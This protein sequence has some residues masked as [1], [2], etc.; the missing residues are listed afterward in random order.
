MTDVDGNDYVDLCCAFGS[1]MSGH[2]HPILQA[3]IKNQLKDGTLFSAPH[4][5]YA[6]VSELL[7]QRFPFDKVRFTNS[8]TESTHDALRVARAFTGREKVV[9][10][11]GGYHGHNELMVSC[12]PPLDKAGD[13]RAPNPILASGGIPQSVLHDTLV[14]PFNDLEALDRILTQHKGEVAAFILEPAPQN[15][16]IVVPDEGYIR[17]VR[18]ITKKHGVL[19]ICDEVKTGITSHWGGA[20]TYFGIQPDLICLAKSIGGGVPVGVF[21]GRAEIMEVLS[22]GKALHLGT[23]NGNSLVLAATRAVLRDIVTPEAFAE[24]KS[25]NERMVNEIQKL[26]NAYKIPAH[27]VQ[28]GAKGCVTFSTH[29]VRNYRDYK[30]TD[31]D[32]ALYHWLFMAN[33]GIFLPPGLDD[34][35]TMS[36]QH[37]E[38]DLDRHVFLFEQFCSAL[39]G[40]HLNSYTP[41]LNSKL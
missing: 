21:G 13:P 14:V 5:L 33:R 8:G 12:K 19:M 39:T 38:A 25:R 9:K 27:T 3:A 15:M 40:K 23:Y 20:S 7:I 17:G 34:Q 24:A 4:D 28:F 6:E 2:A 22:N 26:I 37:T 10:V 32:L 35:W 41:K 16:G 30:A 36:V 11:E 1:L 18:E 31:F 29:R